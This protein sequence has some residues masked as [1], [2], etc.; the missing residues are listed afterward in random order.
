MSN[1]GDLTERLLPIPLLIAERPRSQGELSNYSPGNAAGTQGKSI[2]FG[3]NGF[4]NSRRK[5]DRLKPFFGI[6]VV[7]SFFVDYA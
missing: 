6:P 4:F 1:R 3:E 7:F 5:D 2:R